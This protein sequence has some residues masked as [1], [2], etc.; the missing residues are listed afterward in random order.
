LAQAASPTRV[1]RV[2][3]CLSPCPCSSH[4]MERLLKFAKDNGPSN[5]IAFP[6]QQWDASYDID[7]YPVVGP[8]HEGLDL[9][10]TRLLWTP[11]LSNV[12]VSPVDM[13]TATRNFPVLAVV[14]EYNIANGQPRRPKAVKFAVVRLHGNGCDCG[15]MSRDALLMSMY[16]DAHVLLPEYPGYGVARGHTTE[17]SIDTVARSAAMFAMQV[18][19]V[20]NDRLIIFGRSIGTGPAA[21]LAQWLSERGTPP[22]ALML[23]SPYV[24]I[25]ELSQDMVGFLGRFVLQRWSTQDALPRV[26]APIFIMHGNADEVVPYAHGEALYMNK[27]YYQGPCE[28]HTQYNRGHNDFDVEED[29]LKPGLAFLRKY[30]PVARG[31]GGNMVLDTPSLS[32]FEPVPPEMRIAERKS[33]MDTARWLLRAA[34]RFGDSDVPVSA[35]EF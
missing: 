34:L 8:T 26:M 31:I 33:L 28:L 2:E 15:E 3:G 14:K 7:G 24:G 25:H 17:S 12:D 18:L 6:G 1:G 30:L 19:G 27:D 20:P 9:Y 10:D 21:A 13:A 16:W 22:A 29:Q 23:Q 35:Q 32:N 5:E 11:D 4:H